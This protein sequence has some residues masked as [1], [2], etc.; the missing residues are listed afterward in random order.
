MV[1]AEQG[2]K[3]SPATDKGTT[4]AGSCT[5]LEMEQLGFL[6]IAGDVDGVNALMKLMQEMKKDPPKP[7]VGI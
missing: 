1:E 4:A 5:R 7:N 2:P 3:L 6:G